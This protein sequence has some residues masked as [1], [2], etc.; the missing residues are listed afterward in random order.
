MRFRFTAVAGAI[1]ASSFV[2]S[3]AQAQA[4]I[5]FSGQ[6]RGCFGTLCVGTPTD[7]FLGLTY[8]QNPPSLANPAG[9]FYGTTDESGVANI[10]GSTNNFG[11]LSLTAP[12]SGTDNYNGQTFRLFFDFFSPGTTSGDP[13]FT[14]VL[15]G[16]VH[17]TAQGVSVTFDDNSLPV[18]FGPPGGGTGLVTVNNISVNAGDPAQA[19]SG[20]IASVTTPE[21]ASMTLLATGLI[22]IFGAARRRRKSITA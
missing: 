18:A 16:T 9:G 22:G 11:T 13:I 7:M 17:T 8:V 20:K 1:L 19:L 10:G 6:T 3:P 5:V 15:G 12:V 14:A 21:P 2:S 4:G